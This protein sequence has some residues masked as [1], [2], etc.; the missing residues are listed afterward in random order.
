MKIKFITKERI[1]RFT[2]NNY[3]NSCA[4]ELLYPHFPISVA[5][6]TLRRYGIKLDNRCCYEGNYAIV[7]PYISTDGRIRNVM[8]M[9]IKGNGDI[10]DDGDDKA[11]SQ[12]TK[13]QNSNSPYLSDPHGR[14]YR[15]L[16][17]ELAKGYE[18]EETQCLFGINIGIR[19][20]PLAIVTNPMLAIMM[21][22]ICPA[23]RWVSTCKEKF[24][25]SLCCLDIINDL[26]D[27]S[28]VRL[29]PESDNVIE[30]GHFQDYLLLHGIKA[31][32]WNADTIKGWKH[33]GETSK[34]INKV[35]C[36]L[37][38]GFSYSDIIIA[39]RLYSGE[40]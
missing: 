27:L 35:L 1:Y 29:Y 17:L 37:D 19:S 28:E 40:L 24:D 8:Q 3:A 2:D 25:D 18:F 6:D 11:I 13:K 23:Y 33:T 4:A 5:N 26:E 34:I 31:T 30:A 15:S 9:L 21:S 39:M 38:N 10:V 12:R 36:M 32:V 14:K 7:L 20:K 16:S 22:I